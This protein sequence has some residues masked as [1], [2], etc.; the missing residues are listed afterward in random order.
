MVSARLRTQRSNVTGAGSRVL[1]LIE[2]RRVGNHLEL[3]FPLCSYTLLQAALLC[4]TGTDSGKCMGWIG[5]LASAVAWLHEHHVL[6]RDLKPENALVT[7]QEVVT[8]HDFGH[9]A[10][11]ESGVPAPVQLYYDAARAR[12]SQ[13]L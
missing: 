4:D 6:H 13:S 3:I 8:L 2:A 10:S 5:Q 11:F 9:A 1:L 12:S 7:A